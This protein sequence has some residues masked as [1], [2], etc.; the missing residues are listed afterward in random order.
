MNDPIVINLG[1]P[2]SGTTTLAQALRKAGFRVADYRIRRRDT[3][4]PALRGR[5]VAGQ[6]YKGYFASGDPLETL[7]EFNAFTEISMMRKGHS[8]WP[9]TDWGIIDA[10]RQH[11]PDVRFL[12][13]ARDPQDQAMSMLRWSDMGTERL[14]RSTV[15]GLPRGYGQTTHERARWIAAHHAF[16]RKV[17]E[18]D[19][20]FLEYDVAD[21]GAPAKIGEFLGR[22]LPWWGR[23]NAND[24]GKTSKPRVA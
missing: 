9:Q 18:G 17:F 19:S 23:L 22:E 20:A 4:Q 13:S 15:P 10:L 24:G 11:H 5:F 14:P 3:E 12:A 7:T 1:L 16:L 8:I 6:M 21:A 2:K